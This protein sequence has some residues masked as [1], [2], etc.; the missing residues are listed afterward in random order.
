MEIKIREAEVSDFNRINAL[1]KEFVAFENL[2]E[3]MTNTV[4]QMLEEKEY[5]NCFVAE[6][7]EGE[8][9]GYVTYFF[10]YYTWVGKSLYMDDLYV[11][12]EFRG[13]SI[14]SQLIKKIIVYAKDS[15]C[16]RLRWQV[17]ERNQPAIGFYKK[18]GADVSGVEQN[19]DLV[20]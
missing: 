15:G 2:P 6:T 13:K 18:L 17:S 3:R 10:C 12:P 5:F 8:I 4:E 11:R 16:H 7:T 20:L 14:G 9:A 1:F 19:C